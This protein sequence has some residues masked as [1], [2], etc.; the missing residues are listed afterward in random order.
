MEEAAYF[1]AF[2]NVIMLFLCFL[3]SEYMSIYN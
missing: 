2:G 1:M 3:P